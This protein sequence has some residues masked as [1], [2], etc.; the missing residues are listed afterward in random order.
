MLALMLLACGP[1]DPEPKVATAPA[2]ETAPKPEYWELVGRVTPGTSPWP[3]APPFDGGKA[4][5][6]RCKER[7]PCAAERWRSTSG[8]TMDLLLLERTIHFE[9]CL[10]YTS[11]SPRD[12][13]L[14]RMPSSA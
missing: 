1:T 4:M 12:A 13:T 14:S 10:L 9:D 8:E 6:A 11:P 7:R 3:D 2:T 5:V